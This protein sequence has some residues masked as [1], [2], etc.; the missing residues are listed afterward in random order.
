MY[1]TYTKLKVFL[2]E[3]MLEKWLNEKC[4]LETWAFPRKCDK[5]ILYR[6]TSCFE[7]IVPRIK[8]DISYS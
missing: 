3:K 7:D 2:S 5:A 4:N 1:I 6:Q 8:V